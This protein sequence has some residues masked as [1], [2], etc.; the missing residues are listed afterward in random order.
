[1]EL[2]TSG[3]SV[4]DLNTSFVGGNGRNGLQSNGTTNGGKLRYRF[5][6]G[7]RKLFSVLHCFLDFLLTQLNV[8]RPFYIV[9]Y[10]KLPYYLQH[11]G[12]RG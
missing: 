3:K 2:S 9:C 12:N 11:I 7:D 10:K 8:K 4:V 5:G 1:M 6:R